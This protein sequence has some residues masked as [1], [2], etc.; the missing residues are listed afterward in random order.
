MKGDAYALNHSIF[1]SQRKQRKC[2]MA[3]QAEET[4]HRC[5][6]IILIGP[7]CTGKS[8]LAP[9][10]ADRL[11][12]P[13]VSLDQISLS[14]LEELGDGE[15]TLR[16]VQQETNHGE[17]T[18]RKAQQG[19]LETYR[20]WE[21]FFVTA[22]ERLLSKHFDRIIDLGAGHSHYQDDSLFQR[23]R[24]ALAP[25]P[26]IVLVLPSP[27]LDLSVQILKERSLSQRGYD[28]IADGYDFIEHWVKDRCNHELATLTVYTQDKTP[29]QTCDEIL[30]GRVKERPSLLES[31]RRS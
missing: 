18:F 30:Q 24:Q 5:L 11:R 3:T 10:L 19:F 16:N 8:T 29:E 21:P 12:V 7:V 2:S 14:Y 15:A 26:N 6:E 28:W 25:Y 20:Q 23:V 31:L 1:A 22:L 27:D 17:A 13:Q 4:L 9:L